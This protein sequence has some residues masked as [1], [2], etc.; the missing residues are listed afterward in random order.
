MRLSQYLR[1]QRKR[2]TALVVVLLLLSHLF[3]SFLAA[4]PAAHAVWH[5]DAGDANHHCVVTLI[6][7]GQLLFPELAA[8]L[9]AFVFV[10]LNAA[11]K[12]GPL[13]LDSI[14]LLLPG[15]RAPPVLHIHS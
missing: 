3:A 6:S 4:C 15:G 11:L 8:G 13:Q 7:S 14:D 12:P 9:L 10:W 5:A 2:A 1:E